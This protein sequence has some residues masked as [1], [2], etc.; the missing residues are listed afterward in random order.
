MIL[1]VINAKSD[2]FIVGINLHFFSIK[3]LHFEIK[4]SVDSAHL[5][6]LIRKIYSPLRE[7]RILLRLTFSETIWND[8]IQ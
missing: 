4:G 2:V 6:L 1:S 5:N 3:A 8:K 7:H